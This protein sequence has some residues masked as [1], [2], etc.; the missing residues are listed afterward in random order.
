MI[1]LT[2]VS[3]RRGRFEIHD[4]G[5]ALAQGGYGVVIG[6]AGAGKTTMLETIAG[7]IPARAGKIV[8]ADEDVT[9]AP[10]EDRRLAIVYQHAYLFP[11]LDVAANVR[12]GARDFALADDYAERFGVAAMGARD[13]R[14]LSGGE[15]QLVAL[16]R[17]LAS[18]P[19]ALLLDEPFAALDPR[20]RAGARRALK[21]A[22]A[23]RDLTI[24][25][26]THD[27]AEAGSLGDL[28]LLLDRGRVVQSGTPAEVFTRPATPHAASFL[29]AENIFAG[30]ARP[31]RDTSPDWTE[32]G[33]N[34]YEEHAVA[35]TVG[36]LTMY[37]IGDALPGPINAV[38]RAEEVAISTEP[39]S[40]SVRNQFRG[41]VSEIA[42]AGAITRVTV[43]VGGIPIV[44]AVTTRSVDELS[45]VRGR[46]VVVGFKA[47]AV[48][49]C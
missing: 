11:H 31:I 36:G 38:I 46:E 45:L 25:H 12:Y 43:D 40:S 5:L 8:V 4:V 39:A 17:A 27:F 44:A 2:G 29:G 9:T 6:P 21:V 16:A 33:P 15:R 10:P 19:R 7:L 32:A 20:T 35:L 24:L 1:S 14:S 26:V 34:E 13:V 23:E 28:A 3:A 42:P 37:A 41:S 47:T 49:L 30:V 48:H 22:Q 18:Q